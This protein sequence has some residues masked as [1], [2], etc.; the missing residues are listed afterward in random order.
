M[1]TQQQWTVRTDYLHIFTDGSKDPQTATGSILMIPSYQVE[2]SK[3][4]SYHLNLYTVELFAKMIYSY[5]V[6]LLI[7]SYS[8]SALIR[9]E[10][11]TTE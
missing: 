5:V 2:M 9:I 1:D 6:T 10:T 8:V 11:G 3:S 4:T 7:C